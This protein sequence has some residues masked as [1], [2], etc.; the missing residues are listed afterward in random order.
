MSV[1]LHPV[2]LL[3]GRQPLNCERIVGSQLGTVWA[4]WRVTTGAFA[5]RSN[6]L[7]ATSNGLQP[8]VFRLK[9]VLLETVQPTPTLLDHFVAYLGK[10]RCKPIE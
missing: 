2:R 7:Q 1:V 6:G 3:L 8:T 4:D 9:Q 10:G 5:T